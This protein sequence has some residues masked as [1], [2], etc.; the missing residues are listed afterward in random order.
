MEALSSSETSFR[1][2]ATRRNIPAVSFLRSH[3]RDY[4]KSYIPVIVD[5]VEY[6]IHCYINACMMMKKKNNNNKMMIV[7]II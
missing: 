4:L 2:R 1:I 3:R 6:C 7:Y 5:Y